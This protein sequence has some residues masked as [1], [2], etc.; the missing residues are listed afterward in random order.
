M[1]FQIKH[2]W[3]WMH[4]EDTH[5]L[6]GKTGAHACIK[7]AG[8]KYSTSN[9]T[10][11]IKSPVCEIHTPWKQPTTAKW[12][13]K[14]LAWQEAI[15]C[16]FILSTTIWMGLTIWLVHQCVKPTL[17]LHTEHRTT[18]VQTCPD[19]QLHVNGSLFCSARNPTWMPMK[20]G[21]V[22][23][24]QSDHDCIYVW[25]GMWWLPLSAGTVQ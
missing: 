7:R 18:H 13:W 24:H 3:Q 9:Q 16:L 10:K 21:G 8:V 14:L 4:C 23:C 19:H 11:R 12:R 2:S 1:S 15:V 20:L 25:L 5:R 6:H 22:N 17:P